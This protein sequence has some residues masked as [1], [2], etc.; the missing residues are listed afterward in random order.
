MLSELVALLAKDA[1]L[2]NAMATVASAFLAGCAILVSAISLWVSHA[3]LKHQRH[4]NVLSVRPIP[5]VWVADYE[6]LLVVKVLNNGSG[7]QIVKSIV[8][9]NGSDTKESL[10]EWMPDLPKNIYWTAYAAPVSMRSILPGAEIVL[11]ELRGDMDDPTFVN[12]RNEC[13]RALSQLIV[14]LEYTD[15]YGSEFSRYERPLSWFGRHLPPGEASASSTA[16]DA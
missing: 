6:N 5:M 1:N 15:I 8:V 10:V 12:F 2:T 16:R 3:T 9:R 11:L 13:R 14:A 4:H 7:P